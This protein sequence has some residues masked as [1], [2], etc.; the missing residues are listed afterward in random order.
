MCQLDAVL[1]Q[2]DLCLDE[3]KVLSHI[4]HLLQEL[5]QELSAGSL[6]LSTRPPRQRRRSGDV[7]VSVCVCVSL[8]LSL[9]LSVSLYLSLSI[10]LTEGPF[11]TT[12][13]CSESKAFG[14]LRA[15]GGPTGGAG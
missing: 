10:S 4:S 2:R 13:A 12:R 11:L 5:L 9:S 8:S 14:G 1:S 6:L 3:S 7:S 15:G